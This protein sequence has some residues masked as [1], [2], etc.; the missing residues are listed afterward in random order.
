MNEIENNLLKYSASS[1]WMQSNYFLMENWKWLAIIVLLFLGFAIKWLVNFSL[2]KIQS[3]KNKSFGLPY[4]TE[5]FLTLK[6]DKALSWILT[7]ALWLNVM[8]DLE[9]HKAVHKPLKLF[10]QFILLYFSVKTIYLLTEVVGS[11]IEEYIK[12]TESDLDSQFIILARKTL[13]VFIVVV[14]ILVFLQSTGVNIVSIVAG[15]G[16]GGLAIAFAAQETIANFFGSLIIILDKPFRVGDAIKIAAYE[17]VVEEIGFRSTRIRSAQRSILTIP[18]NLMAKESI[19]NLGARPNRRIHALFGLTYNTPLEKLS[20]FTNTVREVF[21]AHPQSTKA[22]IAVFFTE[23]GSSSLNVTA[24][25]YFYAQTKEE[26]LA[27]QQELL[28]A[29]HNICQRLQIEF[30]YPTQTLYL[31]K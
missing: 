28:F 20:V 19:E 7:C 12:K 2:Q 17:G 3:S 8:D 27:I 11:F 13:K 14:G 29:V 25:G 30:A 21:L 18:N 9:L 23:F 15:L 24:T 6:A 16:V 5:L 4:F 31:K 1:N 22:D 10:I 26:E